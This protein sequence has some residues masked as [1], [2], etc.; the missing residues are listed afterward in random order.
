MIIW[1]RSLLFNIFFPLW[2]AVVA[3][4]FYPFILFAKPKSIAIVGYIWGLVTIKI[5][6]VLCD[7]KLSVRGLE[8]IPN[9]PCIVAS[10]HQSD[11]ET[12]AFHIILKKPVYILKQELLKIPLFG[13]YLSKMGMISIDREGGMNAIKSMI[14]GSRHHLNDQRSVIIF[15]EGTRTAIDDNSNYHPGVHALYNSCDCQILP[16]ALNTGKFWPKGSFIK[17]PGV[18]VIEFL[19]PIAMKIKSNLKKDDF[20]NLIYDKIETKSKKLLND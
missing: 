8:H 14:K 18:F 16:V 5:L 9:E 2:T 17:N 1:L 20:M 19:P 15:P 7:L 4:F 13:K 11:L 10:K 12:I 3:C 6:D